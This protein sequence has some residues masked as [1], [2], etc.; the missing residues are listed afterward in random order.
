MQEHVYTQLIP[1]E[2]YISI[3]FIKLIF[4]PTTTIENHH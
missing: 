1:K 4:I 3:N 2:E